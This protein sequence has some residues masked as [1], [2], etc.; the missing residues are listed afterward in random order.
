MTIGINGY[1]AVISRFGRDPKTGL[2]RR[3]GSGEYCF[4]LLVNLNK[5]DKKNQYIIFLKDCHYSHRSKNHR[6]REHNDSP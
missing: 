3:V 5:I 6:Q 1:E 4:E 2:P